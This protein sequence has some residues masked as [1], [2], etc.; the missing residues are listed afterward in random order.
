MTEVTNGPY[1]GKCPC[2]GMWDLDTGWCDL[3]E[4]RLEVRQDIGNLRCAECL[5]KEQE[6]WY[7]IFKAWREAIRKQ[8]EDYKAAGKEPYRYLKKEYR[9][10]S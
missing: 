5:G 1:C 6:E 3:F 8:D 10:A 9:E 7:P 2:W 4:K